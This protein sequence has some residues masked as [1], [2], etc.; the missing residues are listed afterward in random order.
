MRSIVSFPSLHYDRMMEQTESPAQ[1][2]KTIDEIY[3]T[4]EVL[5]NSTDPT[6]IRILDSAFSVMRIDTDQRL[7]QV[8]APALLGIHHKD[9]SSKVEHQMVDD[10]DLEKF[11]E[12]DE[13]ESSLGVGV[14]GN[15]DVVVIEMSSQ[16]P[17]HQRTR[18]FSMLSLK[19]IKLLEG[20]RSLLQHTGS[21]ASHSP[22]F[23]MKALAPLL[24][25]EITESEQ[26]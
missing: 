12:S 14:A 15:Q 23:P 21:G 10:D 17:K 22:T 13:E 18:A 3:E 2:M 24:H 8:H 5:G 16:Q 1:D 20:I 6:R 26:P 7:I 4:R 11:A 19:E 25:Q 9:L